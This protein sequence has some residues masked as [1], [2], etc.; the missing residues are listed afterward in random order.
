MSNHIMQ[1]SNRVCAVI[2]HNYE[3]DPGHLGYETV[4]ADGTWQ[5]CTVAEATRL[6]M[7]DLGLL[8]YMLTGPYDYL[9]CLGKVALSDW[10]TIYVSIAFKKYKQHGHPA[11]WRLVP[12]A[13]EEMRTTAGYSYERNSRRINESR[14]A[15]L[16]QDDRFVS[17]GKEKEVL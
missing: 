11:A 9:N 14:A 5:P 8:D 3:D 17:F 15:S 2:Q 1:I 7:A 16:I 10:D 6:V 12:Y 4:M 13:V